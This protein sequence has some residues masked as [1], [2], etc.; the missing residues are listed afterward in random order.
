MELLNSL[1]ADSYRKPIHLPSGEELLTA[2]WSEELV[3]NVE[4]SMWAQLNGFK[5]AVKL[6]DSN[7]RAM[8]KAYNKAK[9][10]LMGIY[11]EVD[12]QP[13]I[14][15]VTS[16]SGY[17]EKI[18]LGGTIL[19]CQDSDIRRGASITVLVQATFCR[20]FVIILRARY[21][22]QL[23]TPDWV[24]AAYEMPIWMDP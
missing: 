11:Q 7:E 22:A 19:G 4:T 8:V 20:L 5:R 3:N 10:M 14:D 15:L 18:I 21:G 17:T 13:I 9:H 2:G 24:R 12:G 23:G 16:T 1:T 6:R